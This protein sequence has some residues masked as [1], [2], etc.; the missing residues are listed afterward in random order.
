MEAGAELNAKEAAEHLAAIRRI[1]ESATQLTVLPG[2]AAIVGGLLALIASGITWRALGSWD[3]AEMGDI[4][5]ALRLRLVILWSAVA[6]LGIGFDVV[7]TLM[8][9]RKRGVSAWGRL[10]QLAAYAMGPCVVIGVV[11]TLAFAL[12][13]RWGMVPGIWMLLYGGAIWMT[14]L[15]SVRAP[16]VLGLV[17]FVFGVFTLFWVSPISLIMV[18]ATF[19]LAHIVSG[20]Y[21]LVRFG[22]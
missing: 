7:M 18:A 15:V 16:R 10:S 13:G 17:F 2:K 14:S 8:A 6:V 22:D 12:D 4:D 1:M 5:A 9:A 11:V 3:F 19:G 20:I 21:L